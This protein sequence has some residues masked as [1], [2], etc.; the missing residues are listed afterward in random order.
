MSIR[1]AKEAIVE[2]SEAF[3]L[4][5]TIQDCS[6]C[7]ETLSLYNDVRYAIAGNVYAIARLAKAGYI[8][9]TNPTLED[10]NQAGV[11]LYAQLTPTQQEGLKERRDNKMKITKN[12][13]DVL[14]S[15]THSQY[16]DPGQADGTSRGAIWSNC[17]E[18]D[19]PDRSA[20]NGRAL[21]ATVASLARK[22]LV[23]SDNA[24]WDRKSGMDVSSTYITK[25]GLEIFEIEEKRRGGVE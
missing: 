17:I 12:E 13:Y 8:P 20:L 15:L 6:D 24:G 3:E 11:V 21:S 4:F 14:Y 9:G 7:V 1:V 2:T 23:V 18:L 25:K 10:I 5:G 16:L 19:L 22:G